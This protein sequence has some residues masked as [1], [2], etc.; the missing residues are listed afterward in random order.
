MLSGVVITA[1]LSSNWF[2]KRVPN[3][4]KLTIWQILVI[5]LAKYFVV[6]FFLSNFAT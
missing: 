5:F 2:A 3:N 4:Q 1:P 6:S